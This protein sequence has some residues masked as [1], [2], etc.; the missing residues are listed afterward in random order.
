VYALGGRLG[1]VDSNVS[2]FESYT[3]ATGRWETL[4]PIPE[5][6]G[7][8]GLASADGLLV[9]VG[10]EGPNNTTIGTVYG[11]DLADGSWRRLPDLPTP[12]HGLAVVGIR[13]KVYAIGGSPIADLGFS[14]ANET[15]DP[16]P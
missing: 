11:Y 13:G 14:T 8:S 5:A 12:R 4:A 1:G 16:V 10:G 7:G 6:R 2:T 15:L 3:P 9:S